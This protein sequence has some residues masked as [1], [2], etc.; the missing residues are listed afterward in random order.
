[1]RISDWSS[2]V[3]SSDLIV[4][5]VVQFLRGPFEIGG[6]AALA[7]PDRRVFADRLPAWRPR[8]IARD[9]IIE[10]MGEVEDV[11]VRVRPDGAHRIILVDLVELVARE[12]RVAR[13]VARLAE[14]RQQRRAR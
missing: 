6:L 7:E 5:Q 4:G 8:D 13:R 3:C 12:Y 2:D 14:D 9:R 1:M 10:R 11:A